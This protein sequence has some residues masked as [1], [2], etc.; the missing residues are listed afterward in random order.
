VGTDSRGHVPVNVSIPIET[1]TFVGRMRSSIKG[2]PGTSE[3]EFRGTKVLGRS[4]IQ[5]GQAD[6]ASL[7]MC[8]SW[9]TAWPRLAAGPTS[10]VFDDIAGD[11]QGA[12][13]SKRPLGG[14][15]A[16]Q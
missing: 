12:Y 16:A 15:G 4:V 9:P 14:A 5:V 1:D 3:A 6:S 8:T 2:C 10:G 7:I 13:G 11:V